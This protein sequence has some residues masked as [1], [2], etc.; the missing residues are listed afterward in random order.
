MS[1]MS[2]E[3]RYEI[4]DG[5]VGKAR[6]LCFN[7]S[8]EDIE[9]DMETEDLIEIFQEEMEEHFRQNVQPGEINQDDFLE[10]AKGLF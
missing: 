4:G 6:P 7:I 2:F 5:Y 10:W 3:C 1:K 8:A 9:D